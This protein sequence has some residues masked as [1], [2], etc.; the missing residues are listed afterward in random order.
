MS[1]EAIQKVLLDSVDLIFKLLPQTTPSKQQLGDCLLVSHRG[2]RDNKTIKEN[3]FAA[4]DPVIEKNIWGIEFDVRWTKDLVPIVV[5]D[6]DAKRVFD[7]D[8]VF[9]ENTWEECKKTVPEIPS[10]EQLI[11]RYGKRSHLMIELK[12]EVYPELQRQKDI[13]KNILSPLTPGKDF[14][15]IALDT[16]LFE[17]ADFLP[18]SSMLPVSTVNAKHFSQLTLA[19]DWGGITG[20]Y[21]FMNQTLVTK[22]HQQAQKVG[23]GFA[24]SKNALF[25]EIHKGTDWIFTNEALAMQQILKNHL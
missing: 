7:Q 3:T 5:H 11:E 25:R 12:D 21:L 1:S 14:H 15:I 18:P 13:L 16:Q 8:F 10:L 2:E 4:F 19:S 9:S 22:H 17:R 20:H 6:S 24:N 23:S